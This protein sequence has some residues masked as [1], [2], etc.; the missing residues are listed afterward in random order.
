MAFGL[1]PE[2]FFIK[3]LPDIK[4][5]IE[6]SLRSVF[7][8]GLNLLPTELVGQFVGI[9]S[10]R[11]ALLWEGLLGVYNQFYPETAQGIN[12]DNVVSITGIK[13]LEATKGVGL[14]SRNNAG[15]AYGIEGTI[16]P[17]G[18][19]ISVDG[20]PDARYLTMEEVT[21]GSGTDEV[22]EIEFSAVPD[23]GDWTIVFDGDESGVLAF[24]DNAAAVQAAIN[25]LGALS[26][27][28]VAGNY[29]AGFVVTFAAADGDQD[30]PTLQIGQNTLTNT[31]I[32]VNTLVT[33]TTEGV[34]PNVLVDVQ[35][36]TAGAVP[37]YAN[38]LTVI[39]T[40][41]A[42]WESFNN[43][44]DLTIGK[45]IETDAE[46]R[47]RRLQTLATAGAGTVDAIRSRI[48]EI[49][50]VEDARV[51]ENDTDDVDAFGRPPHSFEAVVLEGQEQEIIDVIWSVKGAGIA[52]YGSITGQAL[53]SMGFSHDVSF[54]RP[55]EIPIFII[56]N[57]D[58]DPD[59]IP[60]D[61][62]AGIAAAL[63][64][65]ATENFGIGDDVITVKMF[66]PIADIEGILDIE[67]LIGLVD[68]PVSDANISIA[69]DQ[70]AIFDTANITVN[71][72]P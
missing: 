10:E 34:M 48:L 68:P 40:P 32:Q 45:E 9:M 33:V 24:N 66:C 67:I 60:D 18:S 50:E 39:E 65:Y 23:A 70:I 61:L 71:V 20:N 3:R 28:T 19:I 25:G 4:L 57:V 62:E 53:D 16:I 13:R 52:T 63:A 31:G 2:G 55:E 8:N 30:Q 36:E 42:G 7:G 14:E 41:I 58:V 1:L 46:L 21:I 43:P 17:S 5:E 59:L 6:T 38:T 26:G 11:E 69:D 22:Q 44:A 49:D 64:E 29:A 27:V 15:I 54:S 47:R 56:V 12:L 37:V 72:S 35:A 51:F